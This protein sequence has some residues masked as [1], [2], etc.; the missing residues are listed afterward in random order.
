MWSRGLNPEP[1]PDLGNWPL[2]IQDCPLSGSLLTIHKQV[3]VSGTSQHEPQSL[4]TGAA[5]A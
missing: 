1:S 5:L 3:Q 2:T 4:I